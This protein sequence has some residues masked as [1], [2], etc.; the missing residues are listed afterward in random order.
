MLLEP[1]PSVV[2]YYSILILCRSE[3]DKENVWGI[4]ITEILVFTLVSFFAAACN[5]VFMSK[6]AEPRTFGDGL[7]A[8]IPLPERLSRWIDDVV[9][10]PIV[11]KTVF[12]PALAHIAFCHGQQV[13]WSCIDLK[14]PFFRYRCQ[15]G[16]VI[17]LANKHVR[18][19]NRELDRQFIYHKHCL[20]AIAVLFKA[21]GRLSSLDD[22]L[23]AT[24]ERLG[25]ERPDLTPIGLVV[26][27]S[28]EL[29]TTWATEPWRYAIRFVFWT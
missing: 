9:L 5:S 16:D 15:T 11:H 10:F 26:S 19:R 27:V 20:S 1:C 13:D 6:T 18:K 24:R 3:A 4:V 28:T 23:A 7:G 14:D 21:D 29:A 12:G 2:A 17:A 22:A 8:S 25:D